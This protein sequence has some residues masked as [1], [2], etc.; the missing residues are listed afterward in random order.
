MI[1]NMYVVFIIFQVLLIILAII[2]V[3][4]QFYIFYKYNDDPVAKYLY[5]TNAI[6]IATT[7]IAAVFSIIV[8]AILNKHNNF[9]IGELENCCPKKY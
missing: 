5:I 7:I 9:V 2:G 8:F 3:Y 6:A 4:L 1:R